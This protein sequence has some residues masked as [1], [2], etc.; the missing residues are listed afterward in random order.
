MVDISAQEQVSPVEI[1]RGSSRQV[2]PKEGRAGG[3]KGRGSLWDK[4]VSE[5]R[6]GS[7]AEMGEETLEDFLCTLALWRKQIC[8]HV[9]NDSFLDGVIPEPESYLGKDAARPE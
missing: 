7:W 6:S 5:M 1:S 4:N 8:Q 3:R 2:G 9:H